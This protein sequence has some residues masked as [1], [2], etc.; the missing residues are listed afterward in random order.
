MI[1]IFFLF[2]KTVVPWKVNLCC[3][4]A[5]LRYHMLICND[6]R[7][8]VPPVFIMAL[9]DST[10]ASVTPWRHFTCSLDAVKKETGKGKIKSEINTNSH[11]GSSR[12]TGFLKQNNRGPTTLKQRPVQHHMPSILHLFYNWHHHIEEFRMI[13]RKPSLW[14]K[15]NPGI[16]TL[17]R[18]FNRLPQL[19]LPSHPIKRFTHQ[20]C[21][22]PGPQTVIRDICL[23]IPLLPI[24]SKR[25]LNRD[26]IWVLRSGGADRHEG[27]SCM[28]R[29]KGVFRRLKNPYWF[30][31]NRKLEISGG[32][33][34]KWLTIGQL[35]Y[36]HMIKTQL[37]RVSMC[38]SDFMLLHSRCVIGLFIFA[39]LMHLWTI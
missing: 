4:C 26:I 19:D 29:Q 15:T 22:S 24:C 38:Q 28:K 10:S 16:K 35:K 12:Q 39:F 18:K 11:P 17:D 30:N 9:A 5:E 1:C 8:R 21:L 6:L 31:W 27:C 34:Q 7:L 20:R 2:I 13:N 33:I 14:F 37:T 3:L 32:I 25:K 36:F 23:W